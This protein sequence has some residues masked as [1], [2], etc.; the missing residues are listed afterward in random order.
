MDEIIFTV[1]V[2]RIAFVDIP[3]LLI[4]YILSYIVIDLSFPI[5]DWKYKTLLASIIS[6][7]IVI[8]IY[9]IDS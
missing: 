9:V 7:I 8:I 6:L 3:T 5:T 4:L 2:V 1:K